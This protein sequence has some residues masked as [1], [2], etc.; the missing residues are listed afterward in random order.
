MI[1]NLIVTSSNVHMQTFLKMIIR[2]WQKQQW[3][4][5]LETAEN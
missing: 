5:E 1:A 4:L 3:E 2:Q